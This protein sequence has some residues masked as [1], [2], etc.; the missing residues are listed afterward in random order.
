MAG[1]TIEV[2]EGTC[3]DGCGKPVTKG[4]SYKQ[5]HDARL[6]GVLG[7]AYKAGEEV[8]FVQDG[9]ATTTDGA[10]A[11]RRYGFPIPPEAKPRK[12]ASRA[13]GTAKKSTAKSTTRKRTTRKPKTAPAAV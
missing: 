3:L 6:R 9:Q 12:R 13:K 11:L 7:R 8:T 10:T 2:P 5:G 1:I 4:R